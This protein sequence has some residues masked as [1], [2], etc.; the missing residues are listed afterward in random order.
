MGYG[1]QGTTKLS[2]QDTIFI[3]TLEKHC[4]SSLFHAKQHVLLQLGDVCPEFFRRQYRAFHHNQEDQNM[5]SNKK[6][7]TQDSSQVPSNEVIAHS[8]SLMWGRAQE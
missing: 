7:E 8:G 6:E 2:V 1:I 5:P 3:L 4:C